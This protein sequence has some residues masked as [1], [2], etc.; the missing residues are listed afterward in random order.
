MVVIE[1]RMVGAVFPTEGSEGIFC[2][3]GNIVYFDLDIGYVEVYMGK[4]VLS[5]TLKIRAL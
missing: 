2:S 1:V 4:N 5:Y 3:T